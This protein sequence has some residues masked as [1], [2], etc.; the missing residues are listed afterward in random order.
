MK[1]EI[2]TAAFLVLLLTAAIVNIHFI[3]RLTDS[4]TALID[5]AASY[6]EKNDWEAAQKK[7]REAS[8]L[9]KKS[10]PY[11]HLV[12][13]HSE[14]EATTDA[15]FDFMKDVYTQEAG[16]VKGSAEAAKSRLDSISSIEKIRFGSGF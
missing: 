12:L 4:V 16:A 1:K 3:T 7:G 11:T 14:I 13:R 2:I 6:A 15:I 8:E 9:W 10:D 5:E